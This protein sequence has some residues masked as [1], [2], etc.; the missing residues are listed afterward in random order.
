MRLAEIKLVG[1]DAHH[2]TAPLRKKN[3][4]EGARR[5]PRLLGFRGWHHG[6]GAAWRR[7]STGC[8][9]LGLEFSDIFLDDRS[10]GALFAFL[11]QGFN[12]Q[13]TAAGKAGLRYL[14]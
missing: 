6:R 12:R 5:P 7:R 11:A 10:N 8:C 2:P 9:N 1:F 4:A 3:G 14:V 13:T